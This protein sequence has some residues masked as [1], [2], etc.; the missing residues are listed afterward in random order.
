MGVLG[1][2]LFGAMGLAEK[3]LVLACVPIGAW[4]VV[5]L[6]RPF[7]SQRA[8]LVAGISYLA[9][10]PALRRPGHRPA[11]RPRPLRRQ[12]VGAVP[13]V[14]CLGPGA[15]CARARAGAGTGTGTEAGAPQAERNGAPRGRPARPPRL[16]PPRGRARRLRSC[17]RHRRAAVWRDRG[18]HLG[19]GRSPAGRRPRARSCRRGDTAGRCHQPSVAHRGAQRR[20]RSGVRLRGASVGRRRRRLGILAPLR[21]RS[22]RGLGPWMGVRAGRPLPARARAR[23]ADSAG[24]PGCGR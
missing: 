12:P 15:V 20:I 5:R 10:A 21:R 4:G 22:D 24:P 9:M 7:G 11:R 3:V 8:S 16:G 18:R 2:V 14:P 23:A 19:R 17:R 6:V 1:T 13:L